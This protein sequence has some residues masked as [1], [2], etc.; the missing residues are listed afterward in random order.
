MAAFRYIVQGRKCDNFFDTKDAELLQTIT[1]ARRQQDIV[2]EK[3][4]TAQYLETN[5]YVAQMTAEVRMQE[6]IVV[7]L[8][9]STP[10]EVIYRASIW[11]SNELEDL[12]QLV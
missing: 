10:G 9:Q 6:E 4:L 7:E 11:S 5:D 2:T 8:F 12:I 1:E 3:Q